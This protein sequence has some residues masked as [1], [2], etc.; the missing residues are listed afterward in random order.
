MSRSASGTCEQP[1]NN[2][3]AKSGLNKSILDQGWG[4]FRR[5]LEYKTAWNGGWL[6]AVP[7]QHTSRTCPCCGHVSKDNRQT[8]AR[9]HCVQCHFEDHADKVG[10]INIL[11]A[12]HA[13]FA[14]EVSDA[15]RSP[16]AGT[17]RGELAPVG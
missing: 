5:Q 8:Q 14:C 11:R 6:I 1:G 9:F 3:K 10:A 12:G 7:P 2:V 17:R 16:A 15:A 4:E 13:R